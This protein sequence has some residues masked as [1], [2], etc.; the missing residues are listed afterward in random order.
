MDGIG[1]GLTQG[2]DMGLERAA[3]DGIAVT[4]VPYQDVGQ[5]VDKVLEKIREGY[6]DPL[7]R[8]HAGQVIIAAGRPPSIRGKVQALADDF[9]ARTMYVSD[10]HNTDYVVS[11]AGTLCL[12]PGLCVPVHDCD[13]GVV[14]GAS[15]SLSLGIPAQAVYQDYGPGKQKHIIFAVLDE[16]GTWLRVDFST[17]ADVGMAPAAPTEI[18]IDPLKDVGPTLIGVGKAS[19]AAPPSN[20]LPPGNWTAVPNSAIKNG[21]R[22]VVGI[23]APGTWTSQDAIDFFGPDWFIENIGAG[24]VTG[25]FTSWVM[26]GIARRDMTLMN[27]PYVTY[28]QAFAETPGGASAPTTSITAPAPAAPPGGN[29]SLLNAFLVLM[30][31]GVAVGTG[32]AIVKR[33]RPSRRQTFHR[34][35]TA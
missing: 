32:V 22:F 19:L 25:R 1:L 18:W 16:S 20:P 9:R 6:K 26:Q 23:V 12:R 15:E 33:T 30:G 34:R 29:T 8:G 24:A 21:L 5:S 7:V 11:A 14:V 17:N 10:P 31:V 2:Q 35:R 13:D 27:T 3:A 28:A 4:E